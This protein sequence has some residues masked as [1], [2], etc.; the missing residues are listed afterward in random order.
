MSSS[1]H[2]QVREALLELALQPRH[3]ADALSRWIPGAVAQGVWVVALDGKWLKLLQAEG[4]AR[5]R[6]VAK[7]VAI[8]VVGQSTEE[9]EKFFKE[10]CASEVVLPREVLVAN[11]THLSTIRLFSLP[12]T[13]PKEIRDIVELQAEK[14]T[15]YAK[16]EILTSFKILE[17]DRSGYS[18]VMLVI[19]H[20]DVIHRTVRLVEVSGLALSRVGC[21]LEGLVNWF[22]LVK[23]AAAA[24]ALSM[25]MDVDGSS[26]TLMV[27]QRGHPYFIRSLPIGGE[28][29]QDDPSHAA[30]R[31]VN[32]VQR[33]IEALEAEGESMKPQEILLTGATDKLGNLKVLIEQKL[34]LPVTLASPW[35]GREVAQN[36]RDNC[37]RLGDVSFAG[38]IGL[39]LAPSQIDL[40]PQSTK[41]RHAFEARAKGLMLLACQSIGVLVL[42]SLLIIGRAQKEQRYYTILR[43][44]YETSS[45]EALQVEEALRQL[46]FVKQRVRQR[47]QLLEAVDTLA[48]SSPEQ[49]R[50]VALNYTRGG[51]IVLKGASQELPK[52]YE[53]V[54]SVDNS[55][56]FGQ[57]EAKRVAKRK[58]G[59]SDV[60]DF[61][62]SC[63]FPTA[64]AAP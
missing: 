57:V 10:A 56:L 47:G 43:R 50:W 18:R 11:P 51:E 64:K 24:Q 21:E 22:H 29:L 38:L 15:P 59:D 3:V 26:T 42:S 49:I 13:D 23:G 52:V 46:G 39:A 63:P 1:K 36:V 41:L 60:T 27:M 31:F 45:Q 62:V 54:A 19:A 7:L 55:P 14:H 61:E 8:P 6:R 58:S 48:R 9:I 20:Q 34:E 53:F 44:L 25:V 4:I 33:S 28:Q 2:R 5:S 16:E 12:S 17:R 40:T 30:E 37:E 32:E 35:A